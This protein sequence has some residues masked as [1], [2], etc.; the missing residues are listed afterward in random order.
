MAD[1]TSID[2]LIKS[3]VAAQDTGATTQAPSATDPTKIRD[4][5]AQFESLLIAQLMKDLRASMTEDEKSEDG[6]NVSPLGDAMNS[7]L[8]LALSRAGGFGLGESLAGAMLRQA[9]PDVPANLD[10]SLLNLPSLDAPSIQAPT[11]AT[12]PSAAPAPATTPAAQPAKH[13]S[14]RVSSR[15]GWRQDPIDGQSR[16]HKGTD[17]AMAYG[18]DV[19]AAT[20]GRVVSVGERS[21]YGL[22]V[23]V[24]HGHGLETRYAHLS[25]AGVRPGDAVGAGDVIAR[26]GNSG[27]STGPHLHFEVLD[28]GQPVDPEA[29]LS[30]V[31]DAPAPES[32]D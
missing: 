16:F 32:R 9:S 27:R 3:A 20:A 14:G 7:E 31:V 15:F 28:R 19:R 22:T 23:V 2:S 6:F 30:T 12:P 8:G 25:S 11:V 13:S 1:F 24:S 17:V 18:Q 5:A 4:L 21:G 10:P 29:W 26:T